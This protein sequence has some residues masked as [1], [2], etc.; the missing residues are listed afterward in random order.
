[1]KSTD[2]RLVRN[3]FS[4]TIWNTIG[5][6]IGFFIPFF[7]AAWFGLNIRTDAFFFVYGV[8]IYLTGIFGTSLE[9][10]V[11]PFIAK[12]KAG[13]KEDLSQFMSR[14]LS[15]ALVA[16]AGLTVLFIVFI[17]PVS[18]LITHFP[19]SSHGLLFRL[20]IE[21]SPLLIL[22]V[23]ASILAGLLNAH[24]KFWLPAVSTGIRALI[25][26]IVI[27]ITKDRFGIH[28][29][30]LGYVLGEAV[31]LL[32][33]MGFVAR[34]KIISFRFSLDLSPELKTFFKTLSFQ[35]ISMLAIGLNPLVDKVMASWL[36]IGS[37]STIQ[38]AH[39]LYFIPT[40][41]IISGPMVVILSDWSNR[42]HKHNNIKIL[43][44]DMHKAIKVL[45]A[46]SIFIMLILFAFNRQLVN[47]AYARGEFPMELLGVVGITFL[48][49]L[50]GLV[51]YLLSQL[52]VRAHLVIRNTK[53]LMKTA[54]I[55]NILNISLNLVFMRFFGV[56]GIALSTSFTVM[57]T[58]AYLYWSFQVKNREL[59]SAGAK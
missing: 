56:K 40:A 21:I 23:L 5:K 30:T 18:R 27:F 38:Y 37:V 8:I 45:A 49:Y 9:N 16:M 50:A 26:L 6:G 34:E 43:K 48:C 35:V 1:M 39:R 54:F 15:A 17:G 42:Y 55:S 29:I 51:F 47:I 24:F 44:D 28:S 12:I 19:V 11:V 10:N 3:I 32:I 52:V 25:C 46:A 2:N 31:R 53:T 59:S 33:F 58:F 22:L 20:F 4:T 41:F 36:E 57:A 7:I 13:G 14:L